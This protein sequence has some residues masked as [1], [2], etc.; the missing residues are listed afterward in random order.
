V[1]QKL[2]CSETVSRNANPRPIYS[3]FP[4]GQD[5][6]LSL[7]APQ[8]R[9]PWL[10]RVSCYGVICTVYVCTNTVCIAAGN[11]CKSVK[12]IGSHLPSDPPCIISH[13]WPC[14]RSAVSG[15][16]RP[17]P[18]LDW[19][20]EPK[21]HQGT[22]GKSQQKQEQTSRRTTGLASLAGRHAGQD[23]RL[24]ISLARVFFFNKSPLSC[25]PC[26][27]PSSRNSPSFL[28][29]YAVSC[30]SV[31]RPVFALHLRNT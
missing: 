5:I 27:G 23:Q 9:T 22:L 26:L 31:L 29:F 28:V 24:L 19:T 11:A 10:L 18:G 14:P 25:P 17:L 16:C 7:R 13:V 21:M 12:A 20:G 6:P 4:R 1:D 2:T 30:V 3:R 8:D 15:S